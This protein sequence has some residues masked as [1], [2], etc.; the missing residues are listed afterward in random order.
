MDVQT[1]KNSIRSFIRRNSTIVTPLGDVEIVEEIG[2]GG[3]AVVFSARWGG[4]AAVKFLAED[5]SSEEPARYRRF[6][7]EF[8][9]LIKLSHTGAV[10]NLYYFG[11]LETEGGMFPYVIMELC[12][13]TLKKW[14][15]SNPIRSWEDLAPVLKQVLTCVGTVSDHGIVHRD[16]KPQNVLIKGDGRLVLADFGIAWFDP[17]HY[18]RRAET[19]RG[20]RLANREFSAPEQERRRIDDPRPTMDIYAVGQLIQWLVTG[21]V[22]MGTGRRALRTVDESFAPLDPVV[23]AMLQYDPAHRPPN[24][25]ALVHMINRSMRNAQDRHDEREERLV[26]AALEKFDGA[27]ADSFPGRHGLFREADPIKTER[28]LQNLASLAGQL[29]SFG[30]WWSRGGSNLEIK[31]MRRLDDGSWLIGNEECRVREAWVNRLPGDLDRQYVLLDCEPMP[32]FG[33]YEADDFETEEAAWFRDRYIT[34]AEFDDN[35]AEIDGEV[36]RL[37]DEAELRV[38]WK[39]RAFMFVGSKVNTVVWPGE[40]MENDE[41]VDHVYK[42]LKWW[43]EVTPLRL[44]P[45][46]NT[47]V[48]PLSKMWS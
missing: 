46:M 48:H 22:H 30:L 13:S 17:N 25:E 40:N 28:L 14:R 11:V 7:T 18:E 38:R 2:E 12:D 8:R 4:E 3:Y 23:E 34:R 44:E 39:V 6:V 42:Q 5:I 26:L 37:N 41:V 16:I 15:D 29:N 36:V 27:L 47:R 32:P 31:Q 20:E 45:L 24:V 10:V 1:A 35:R 43:E 33:L 21:T 19:R 9:E